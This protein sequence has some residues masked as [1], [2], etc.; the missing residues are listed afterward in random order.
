MK[1]LI[2]VFIAILGIMSCNHRQV[3]NNV[4]EIDSSLV[5]TI[6][7]DTISLDSIICPL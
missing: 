2:F 3:V 1:K 7:L 4:E 6:C 5:D